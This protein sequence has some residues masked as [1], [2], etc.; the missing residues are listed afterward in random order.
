LY[1]LFFR[2]K[3]IVHAVSRN[4]EERIHNTLVYVFHSVNIIATL[5]LL[6]SVLFNQY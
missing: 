1:V 5:F 4:P 2:M 3:N 6:S